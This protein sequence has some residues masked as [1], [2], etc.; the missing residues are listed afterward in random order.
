MTR[1]ARCED[2]VNLTVPIEREAG[3]CLGW[4]S[5]R[6]QY[7]LLSLSVFLFLAGARHY[8]LLSFLGLVQVRE[9]ESSRTLSKR[10]AFATSGILGHPSPVVCGSTVAYLG[11]R[12]RIDDSVHKFCTQS[13][14]VI[15]AFLEE[16]KLIKEFG[17]DTVI[18]K[19]GSR[20]CFLEMDQKEIASTAM[21]I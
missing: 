9:E 5:C 4:C 6:R 3:F 17:D 12:F 8:S 18:T 20:C 21:N 1:R 13:V 19:T 14:S 10:A 15:G 11:A 2:G 16:R 7:G